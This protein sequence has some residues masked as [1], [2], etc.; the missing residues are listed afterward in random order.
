[1]PAK[2]DAVAS[3]HIL[4]LQVL[5][6]KRLQRGRFVDRRK[7]HLVAHQ[8]QEIRPAGAAGLR[9]SGPGRPEPGDRRRAES[10][11]RKAAGLQEATPAQGRLVVI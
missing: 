1:M 6:P 4:C 8:D 11:R 7:P 2:L 3:Q 5:Q 9:L 10:R